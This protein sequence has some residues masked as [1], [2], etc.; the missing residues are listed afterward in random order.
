MKNLVSVAH[1]KSLL[2]CGLLL[3]VGSP[4]GFGDMVKCVY[5]VN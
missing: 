3:A 2:L 1:V 5:L 4:G